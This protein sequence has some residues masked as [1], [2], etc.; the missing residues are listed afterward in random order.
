MHI[1][2]VY[3]QGRPA[4]TFEFFPP[5]TEKSSEQLKRAVKE[6]EELGPDA[7]SVTYGAGGS[8]RELTHELVL[9]LLKTTNLTVICHL[10]TVGTT[11]DETARILDTY[12]ESGVENIMALRGDPPGGG[13][14]NFETTPGGFEYAADLVSFI[15]NRYPHLGI[16]VAGFPEGHPATPNRLDEIKHL[17]AKVDAGADYVCTQLF[18]DNHDFYDW[19][20]RCRYA[21]IEVPL[22]AG[23]MP[24]TSRKGMAKMAELAA[25]SRFPAPLLNAIDRAEKDALV[26]NVGVHWATQQVWELLDNGVDGIHFYTLNRSRATRRIF[27]SLGVSTGEALGKNPQTAG[28]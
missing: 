27:E 21:G 11:R 18:F 17:K 5:K 26:E 1:R 24:I 3:K 12:V 22:V 9:Q 25:G 15:K 13:V 28:A 6:L 7:V 20:E 14:L 8:T 16:G 23:I 10:T 4:F 19:R 2:D